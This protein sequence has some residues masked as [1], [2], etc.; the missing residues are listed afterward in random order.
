MTRKGPSV[1]GE[2]GKRRKGTQILRLWRE[3]E[4]GSRKKKRGRASKFATRGKRGGGRRKE[5][6]TA[7]F[8]LLI[9]SQR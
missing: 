3:K 2:G 8:S 5:A 4:E 7:A 9:V 6:R 1:A